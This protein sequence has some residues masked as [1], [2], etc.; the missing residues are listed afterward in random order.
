MR[1]HRET[2]RERARERQRGGREFTRD[3]NHYYVNGRALFPRCVFPV[4]QKCEKDYHL[5]MGYKV[6]LLVWIHTRMIEIVSVL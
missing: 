4:R 1:T 5:Q 2:G 3:V 6:S